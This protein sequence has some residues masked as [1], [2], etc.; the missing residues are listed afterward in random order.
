ML[1]LGESGTGKE[2]VARAIHFNSD[3][4]LRPFIAINCASIPEALIESELF[5]HEKGAFTNA[6]IQKKGRFE[7][8]HGG[9]IFLDEIGELTPGLQ[10]KLLRVIQEREIERLGGIKPIKIDVRIIAA[11]HSWR[12][13][14]RNDQAVDLA[15][16]LE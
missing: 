2:L 3:R 5:G 4:T 16:L 1:I 11:T 14:R 6:I 12:H 15:Q 13:P 10:A 9:T 8:A 7:L